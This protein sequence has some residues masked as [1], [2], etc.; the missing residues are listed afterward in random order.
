MKGFST[1]RALSITKAKRKISN[2]KQGLCSFLFCQ[3]S[4]VH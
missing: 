2:N 1:R 4:I 3:H